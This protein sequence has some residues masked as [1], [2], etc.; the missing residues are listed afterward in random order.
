M[1]PFNTP[2]AMDPAPAA[3]PPVV[4]VVIVDRRTQLRGPM[5]YRGWNYVVMR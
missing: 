1:A 2:T 3:N 5:L 4:L